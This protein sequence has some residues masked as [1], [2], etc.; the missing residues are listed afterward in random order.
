MGQMLN[1]ATP[2]RSGHFTLDEPTFISIQGMCQKGEL[3]QAKAMMRSIDVN[4]AFGESFVES[5]GSPISGQVVVVHPQ[6]GEIKAGRRALVFGEGDGAW[7]LVRTAAD[8]KEFEAALCNPDS[9][10][11]LVKEWQKELMAPKK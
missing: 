6:F 11:V 2:P 7:M 1:L 9:L 8:S 5:L 3:D 4:G 10:S